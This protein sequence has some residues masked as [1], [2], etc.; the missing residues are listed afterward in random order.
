MQW[1]LGKHKIQDNDTKFADKALLNCQVQQLNRDR[2][3]QLHI[4]GIENTH[5]PI[6]LPGTP[7]SKEKGGRSR[8]AQECARDA[9][10]RRTGWEGPFPGVSQQS[11]FTHLT[12]TSACLSPCSEMPGGETLLWPLSSA[13]SLNSE[14][15]QLPG[16]QRV[17]PPR[18]WKFLAKSRLS[19][20]ISARRE[21]SGRLTEDK[22]TILRVLLCSWL[23]VKC[24]S[25]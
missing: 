18:L 25:L 7:K 12:W 9:D 10:L 23:E 24:G 1:D 16:K 3:S 2:K 13:R 15:N 21:I 5:T 6:S 8:R 22:E 11:A 20:W 4:H 19:A 17:T 14:W